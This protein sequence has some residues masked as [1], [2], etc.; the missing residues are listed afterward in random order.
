MEPRM[1]KI[2]LFQFN[3]M[4]FDPDKTHYLIDTEQSDLYK[5]AIELLG[6]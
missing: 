5:F 4:G 1:P 6:M 2:K 3:K